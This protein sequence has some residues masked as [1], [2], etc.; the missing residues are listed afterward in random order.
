MTCL[1]KHFDYVIGNVMEKT[2]SAILNL[3][4]FE[5]L[6]RNFQ[7]CDENQ[8]DQNETDLILRDQAKTCKMDEWNLPIPSR[9]QKGW[10]KNRNLF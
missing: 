4:T 6:A 7:N 3:W 10:Q 1:K 8:P 9:D 5:G 2:A